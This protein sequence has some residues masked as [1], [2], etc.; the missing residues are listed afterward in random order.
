MCTALIEACT[1]PV[2]KG[3]PAV[4]A[5]LGFRLHA[6]VSS[7]CAHLAPEL[8]KRTCCDKSIHLASLFPLPG[9]TRPPEGIMLHPQTWDVQRRAWPHERSRGCAVHADTVYI[10]EAVEALLR[11]IKLPRPNPL[12]ARCTKPQTR[13]RTH[14]RCAYITRAHVPAM[15]P[16]CADVERCV[17]NANV[18]L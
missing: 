7:L 5:A 4:V 11:S 3:G 16:E 12:P 1:K 13:V 8:N 9:Y 17:H 15:Q 10:H 2:V 6:G 18:M 14:F